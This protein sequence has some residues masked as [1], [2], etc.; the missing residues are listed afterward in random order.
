MR[1]L[2]IFSTAAVLLGCASYPAPARYAD[3]T[4]ADV[5]CI[6]AN[7][8]PNFIKVHTEGE[9]HVWIKEVDGAAT[10]DDSKVC[11]PA[12]AHKLGIQAFN[13]HAHSTVLVDVEVLPGR[14][15]YLIAH[16]PGVS[17]HY[18]LLDES[19]SPATSVL[20]FSG[21]GRVR[22]APTFVPIVVPRAR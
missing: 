4:G 14:N 10:R 12:G 11:V 21:L 8:W 13:R 15:Y 22:A 9:A 20:T 2:L 16:K 17:F 6:R 3:A 1:L 7:T 19:T 5:A 18:V